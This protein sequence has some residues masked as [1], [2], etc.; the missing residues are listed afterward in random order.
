MSKA[1]AYEDAVYRFFGS[2]PEVS[3]INGV[4]FEKATKNRIYFNIGH[5]A[6]S[7]Y[8]YD[9]GN[10]PVFVRKKDL[11]VEI[12]DK[13]TGDIVTAKYCNQYK[14]DDDD[15]WDEVYK[16]EAEDREAERMELISKICKDKLMKKIS[17]NRQYRRKMQ[18]KQLIQHRLSK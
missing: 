6:L 14:Q 15:F 4:N 9:D 13:E 17:R 18:R 3:F 16:W 7:V 11:S 5:V 8:G 12:Y 1:I 2:I 10:V